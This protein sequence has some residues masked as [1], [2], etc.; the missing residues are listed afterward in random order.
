MKVKEL[1][2][3][4][5]KVHPEAEVEIEVYRDRV[6]PTHVEASWYGTPYNKVAIIQT[7]VSEETPELIEARADAKKYKEIVS[8]IYRYL[9]EKY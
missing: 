7:S 6:Y 1:I 5:K 2:A 9:K 3:R 8:H 4:L